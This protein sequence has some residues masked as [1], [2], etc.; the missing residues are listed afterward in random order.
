MTVDQSANGALLTEQEARRLTDR[1]RLALDRVSTAWADLGE[2]ITDAYQRRADLALGYDSWAEYA[3]AELK[4]TEGLAIEI[5]R[6]LVGMLS[7]AGM[8]TRAIAPTVGVSNYTVNKDQQVL[9][10]LTPELEPDA[11]LTAAV[12]PRYSSPEPEHIDPATGEIETLDDYRARVLTD[13]EATGK[14]I[15]LTGPQSVADPTPAKAITGLDGKT[16]TR[17]EPV[18]PRR[19][20]WPEAADHAAA[21]LDQLVVTITNLARD[22]RAPKYTGNEAPPRFRKSLAEAINAL[23][24]VHTQLTEG[25]Q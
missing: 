10:D 9:D 22:D 3:E 18:K 19:K 5:R 23:Q 4:P 13:A 11:A 24:R 1:I 15:K 7:S 14:I 20:P 25:Q 8:S 21:R 17:P 2:R 16:Y 6:Q 12:T